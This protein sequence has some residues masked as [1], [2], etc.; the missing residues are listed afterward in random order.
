MFDNGDATGTV[1]EVR[2]GA[3]L[4]AGDDIEIEATTKVDLNAIAGSVS[5]S[6]IAALGASVTIERVHFKTDA[7][8]AGTIQDA[9]SVRIQS[10]F[11]NDVD[12]R[13]LAGQGALFGA[14]GAAVTSIRDESSTTARVDGSPTT[15]ASIQQAGA[16]TVNATSSTNLEGSTGQGAL[17]LG[18]AAGVTVTKVIADGKTSALV[19]DNVNVGG[20]PGKIVE[21]LTV[22]ANAT[23]TATS[24]A[25]A[26]AAGVGG[27]ATLN[28]AT[29]EVTPAIEAS[30]GSRT[31]A[32]N[33]NIV[34]S[35][36]VGV[37][38]ISNSDA[39]ADL[40][41]LQLAA[42]AA[43]G[44]SRSKATVASDLDAAIG[45]NTTV[46]AGGSVAILAQHNKPTVLTL[47]NGTTRTIT[48][49]AD[50]QAEAGALAAIAGN[51]ARAF[52]FSN[53]S[54]EA[55]VFDGA[56]ITSDA[57]VT[58]ISD[59]TNNVSSTGGSLTLG[60]AG[61]GGVETTADIDGI[62]SAALRNNA[63][64][65]ATSLDVRSMTNDRAISEGRAATGGILSGNA[66]T[67]SASIKNARNAS[68]SSVSVLGSTINVTDSV[69]II[70]DQEADADAFAKGT[71]IGG[72]LAAGKSEASVVV[73]PSVKA[74]VSSS[75]IVAGAIVDIG[76]NFG[77]GS[78]PSVTA[79]NTEEADALADDEISTAFAKGSG[80]ALIGLVGSSATS[81]YRP[82][83]ITEVGPAVSITGLNVIV[84][85]EAD[86]GTAAIAR[87]VAVGFV[88]R[89][90]ADTNVDMKNTV[91]AEVVGGPEF[92]ETHIDAANNFTLRVDSSQKGDAFSHSRAVAGVSIG[93]ANSAIT[94]DYDLNA[95]IG[96]NVDVAA[97]GVIHIESEID[98]ADFGSQQTNDPR[99]P[100]ERFGANAQADTGGI[101]ADSHANAITRLGTATI[102]AQSL[103]AVGRFSTLTAPTV[104]LISDVTDIHV[105]SDANARAAGA[106]VIVVSN[107]TGE[108]HSDS[109]VLLSDGSSIDATSTTI[110]SLHGSG[111]TLRMEVESTTDK[112]GAFGDPS[113]RVIIRQ[114]SLSKIDASD[115]SSIRTRNLTVRADT[116]VSEFKAT[117]LEN[118]LVRSGSGGII[119]S[120][121]RDRNIVWNA[122]V[123]LNGALRRSLL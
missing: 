69:R 114:D 17:A 7:F 67:A 101:V 74:D 20:Q 43:L 11:N 28:F 70:A 58:V 94:G 45:R 119:S 97:G 33:S 1:A 42:G 91:A 49:G 60:L 56:S 14:L 102:P 122:D 83:A 16:V 108:L 111:S 62:A 79:R 35:G 27:A 81:I 31:V 9:D 25:F 112:D 46:D 64:I 48:R 30:L 63:I 4:A 65:N 116:N 15:T 96:T 95:S 2:E 23:T 5:G 120:F 93:D 24:H 75:T 90:K 32:S 107:S 105:Q 53:P 115:G 68:N 118:G 3:I 29:A 121:D 8:F 55:I 73:I 50:A 10:N 82:S 37:K 80:G 72:I 18:G 110:E 19:R 123:Y 34:V 88:A 41:G 22:D 54:V 59:S 84:S 71:S 12:G 38:A 47:P 78:A 86:S 113:S 66:T 99:D 13:S 104:E 106:A 39:N 40:F 87:N 51:T 52:S 57:A 26:L 117:S 44:F 85:S 109:K 89:G 6:A 77:D 76:A 61:A 21:S 36:N 103:V 100:S 98:D 92:S